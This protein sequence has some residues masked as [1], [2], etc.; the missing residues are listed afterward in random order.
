MQGETRSIVR[1]IVSLPGGLRHD[2]PLSERERGIDQATRAILHELEVDRRTREC[3][4]AVAELLPTLARL[5]G[6][7][8]FEL[9]MLHACVVDCP[10]DAV[11]AL[12]AS[13][14]VTG[15]WADSV[16]PAMSVA[17]SATTGVAPS[18][19]R[20]IGVEH[21]R[22]SFAHQ[23][24]FTGAGSS[25]WAPVA[26][27]LDGWLL[28]EFGSVQRHHAGLHQG[29]SLSQ[30][31][32]VLADLD[33]NTPATPLPMRPL[34]A[35][36]VGTTNLYHGLGIAGVLAGAATNGPNLFS[37]APGHAPGAGLV[38]MNILASLPPT[39]PQAPCLGF[40]ADPTGYWAYQSQVLGGLNTLAARR[41]TYTGTSQPTRPIL[42]AN[43]SYGGPTNP[44]HIVNDAMR[45][46]AWDYDIL[47]VT[48]A[49]NTGARAYESYYNLNG[50]AVGAYEFN[51]V[52][53][54][55][56]WVRPVAAWS[57]RG[58]QRQPVNVM[59]GTASG[60]DWCLAGGDSNSSWGHPNGSFG[61]TFPD[62]GA[63]GGLSQV[64]MQDNEA[65]ADPELQ[66]GTSIAAPHVSGAALL[67]A[68]G[69]DGQVPTR[70]PT[71]METRAV[72]LAT[73]ENSTADGNGDN[74]VG[75]GF[76]R[77]DRVTY[78]KAVSELAFD[79]VIQATGVGATNQ[80]GQFTVVAGDRYAVAITWFADASTLG[81]T[82]PN[83][84]DADLLLT[85][86]D[87]SQ[88]TG[89]DPL[90]NRTWERLEFTAP[91][92]GRVMIDAIV[93]RVSSGMPSR[94]V[95]SFASCRLGTPATAPGTVV[96]TPTS[97]PASTCGVMQTAP[98]STATSTTWQYNTGL[99]AY[100]Y[101]GA[102]QQLDYRAI[103]GMPS[104][105]G[106]GWIAFRLD[107]AGYAFQGGMWPNQ[108][109]YWTSTNGFS[110]LLTATMVSLRTNSPTERVVPCALLSGDSTAFSGPN[111]NN[112]WGGFMRIP[113]GGGYS[114]AEFRAMLPA[115]TPANQQ[116]R[117]FAVQL[118]PDVVC[119]YRRF[120]TNN[121]TNPACTI[122]AQNLT[123]CSQFRMS[124]DSVGQA[125]AGGGAMSFDL[126]VLGAGTLVSGHPT[127][128]AIGNP[129]LTA[130][131][132][133]FLLGGNEQ[134]NPAV[135]D[136]ALLVIDVAATE[137]SA[138]SVFEPLVNGTCRSLVNGSSL[139]LTYSG[140]YGTNA[141]ISM[142]NPLV[143]TSGRLQVAIGANPLFL[144]APLHFQAL[145]TAVNNGL[146]Q[147]RPTNV[148]S[149]TFGL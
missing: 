33:W 49:G 8:A 146:L 132:L 75:A 36:G 53:S 59:Y 7:V 26:A 139:L 119:G 106:D 43:L 16:S 46:L 65:I 131:S 134:Q 141:G 39:T 95:C 45:M 14:K 111:S 89:A 87:G 86:P 113:A 41:F 11:A 51:R 58:P 99:G 60:P 40:P 96:S 18:D 120:I 84:L 142:T 20:P 109:C 82:A 127:L 32:R 54:G 1:Y 34:P 91:R 133:D 10:P 80:L 147:V 6:S 67:F 103:T 145:A 98:G 63:I 144:G 76:L 73:P 83:W 110:G 112:R 17:T 149:V 35:P 44:T 56:N 71:A 102:P 19:P 105:S 61:R 70:I 2:L 29:G 130:G 5:G 125:W 137:T 74:A 121:S 128:A 57:A 48:A 88:I 123:Y 30:P 140:A 124:T 66:E 94:L 72:L 68:N 122:G 27:V 79:S 148:L 116:I 50:L 100:P 104:V 114:T 13:P 90:G 129:S 143:G 108:T 115:G 55:G 138:I 107:G 31:T 136:T 64:M 24:G 93:Q 77:T 12:R 42:V 101:L 69:P 117:W 47:V 22:A 38:A 28:G 92:D 37:F 4:N 118:P 9:P 21:H 126:E 23:S 3:A 135:L 81:I 78:A 52:G 15:V 62:I 25:S 97:A 85:M